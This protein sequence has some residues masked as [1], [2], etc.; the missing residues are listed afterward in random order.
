ML[1]ATDSTFATSIISLLVATD[2]IFATRIISML[3]ATDSTF[4][5]NIISLLAATDS[6]FATSIDEHQTA[7]PLGRHRSLFF[8]SSVL[9]LKF[10]VKR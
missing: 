7:N 3:V 8:R 4:A 1:V 10:S 5:T 2:S 6:I 9:I